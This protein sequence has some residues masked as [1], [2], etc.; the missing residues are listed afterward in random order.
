MEGGSRRTIRVANRSLTYT[1]P[2]L[3]ELHGIENTTKLI[4]AFWESLRMKLAKESGFECPAAGC[5]REAKF[6]RAAVQ[7]FIHPVG[8]V[9]ATYYLVEC[10]KHD[11]K[12]IAIDLQ[13]LTLRNKN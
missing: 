2:P 5:G 9:K 12:L 3:K 13:P 7:E 4:K 6:V 1:S 8:G 11:Q 10:A